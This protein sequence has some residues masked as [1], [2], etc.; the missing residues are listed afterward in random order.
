M[1]SIR[2]P[3][4]FLLLVFSGAVQAQECSCPQADQLRPI[5]GKYFNTGKLD[6]AAFVLGQLAVSPNEV[7]RIVN[8]DGLA[9]V[10]ISKKQFEAARRFLKQEEKLQ[11]KLTCNKLL[12]RFYNTMS[13]FYQETSQGDSSSMMSL[14]VMALAEQERDWYAAAR[15]S[16]NLASVFHQQKQEDKA[17]YYNL[18]ALPY[19]RKSGDSIILAAVL[20]R[21]SDAYFVRYNST[22]NLKYLDSVYVLSRE[23]VTL[24]RN[25]PSHLIES[26]GAYTQLS[27][28]FLEKK[29]FSQALAYADTAIS[30]C[31]KG[32]HDFDR[33]LLNAYSAKSET[34]FQLKNYQR[35]RTMAD[36]AYRYAK[37]F[38]IQ[39]TIKPLESIFK[40]SKALKDF[41]RASWAQERGMQIRDSIFTIEKNAVIN[42]LERKYTQAENERTI[43]ELSQEKEISDLRIRLLIIGI[44]T[45][46]V[47]IALIVFVYRTSLLK[48]RQQVIESRYR[49]NQALINPHFLSNALVS[50][51]RFMLENNPAEA[52]N[53]LTKFSRLM[54]QLLEYSR[55]D[56]ITV[57]EEIDLLKNY[58]DLQKL[59]YKNEFDYD[60]DIAEGLSIFDSKIPP[61]FIQPFIEN[62]VE[63]G[64]A[65][66]ENGKI[67]V[68]FYKQ[69][70]QLFVTIVDNGQGISATANDQ[71]SVSTVIIRERIDLLNKTSGNKIRLS[72]VNNPDSKGVCVTLQLPISS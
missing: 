53:Y 36:S 44:F 61:M 39:L 29:E 66:V 45:A 72:I 37:R 33:H 17:L 25:K 48:Q 38:N 28:Y 41:E 23:S 68:S 27:N 46:L 55:E 71:Q 11:L 51:Q 59:R 31:P 2:Y 13:R 14:R 35:A 3:L 18:R 56:L 64:V 30:L 20:N 34:W 70:E 21:T 10:N 57:E 42:E 62:A 24:S 50:I 8:L 47:A 1:M 49:L 52:S 65:G 22:R 63:H 58:L 43:R 26:P 6:S 54:R 4:I 12:I 19:A 7:C 40:T 16:T 67:T 15:A 9:Q 60:I 32:V 5:I 69:Y